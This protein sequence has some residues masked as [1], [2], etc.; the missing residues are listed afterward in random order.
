MRNHTTLTIEYLL[1]L[2]NRC[3]C[4]RTFKRVTLTVTSFNI[5]K[6]MNS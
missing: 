3:L 6:T 4:P 1:Q 2:S 5:S